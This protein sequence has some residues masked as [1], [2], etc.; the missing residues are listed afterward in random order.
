MKEGELSFS[1]DCENLLIQDLHQHTE[2]ETYLVV[3]V[4]QHEVHEEGLA[5]AKSPRHWNGHHLAISDL[6]IQQDATQRRLIQ[7]EGV[8]VF[9]QKHLDG[10]G[11]SI[12]L[13]F[14]RAPV[15]DIFVTE[16]PWRTK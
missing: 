4:A 9:D 13:L 6:L 2:A 3:H 15:I 14:L 11:S 7:L 16:G 1:L 5:L 8:V 12:R 10:P